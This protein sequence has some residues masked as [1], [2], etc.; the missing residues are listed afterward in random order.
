MSLQAN[1]TNN[2][3]RMNMA[4]AI[5]KYYME[6]AK[7]VI[8]DRAFPFID[9]FKPVTRFVIYDMH[10]LKAEGSTNK[11]CARI[12][13]DT[14]GRFHPHGDSSIYG[15][16]VNM[17]DVHE[18]LNAPLIKG[19][20]SF[21]KSW[22][23][24]HYVP[25]AMRYTEASLS[26][27][28]KN[29][30][31]GGL[32]EN[33]VD[34]VDNFSLEEKQPRL[35]PVSFPNILVNNTNGVAVGTS[36]YIPTYTLAGACK[37]VEALITNTEITDEELV[38]ILGAPDFCTG[39]NIHI[40]QHQMLKLVRDGY[41]KGVYLRGNYSI[42]K[43]Q[44][45]IHELPYNTT[46]ERFISEI[47]DLHV[48]GMLKGVKKIDNTSGRD[49]KTSKKK[50]NSKCKM[51][52]ELEL[53][54]GVDPEAIMKVIRQNTSFSNSIAFFTR[55]AWWNEDTQD[56]EY[57]ECG[58]RDL[59]DKYWIPWR[60]SCLRRQ[61]TFKL[62]S[63]EADYHELESW[64]ILMN[65]L[66]EYVAFARCHKKAETK[67]FLIQKLGLDEGQAN[68][69]FA[70]RLS[71]LTTDEAEKSM[72]ELKATA[73]RIAELKDIL[74]GDLRLKKMIL[75]DMRRIISKYA[76][77][78]HSNV[79]DMSMINADKE[80]KSAPEV[81]EDLPVYLAVTETGGVKRVFKE[82]NLSKLSSWADTQKVTDV[83]SCR[84]IDMLMIFTE[85]G[86]CYKIPVH[87]IDMTYGTFRDNIWRLV[88]RADDDNGRI[89]HVHATHD[90]VGGFKILY[91]N[92]TGMVVNYSAVGGK[93]QRYKSV[94]PAF[95]LGKTGIMW[96]DNKFYMVT[97]NKCGAYIDLTDL[98]TYS[99]LRGKAP[100]KLPRMKADDSL[101]GFVP[102]N[103]IEFAH[104]IKKERLSKPYCVK[105]GYDYDYILNLYHPE[106][107]NTEDSAENTEQ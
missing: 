63:A 32:N 80:E 40:T 52:I 24:E 86:Y 9:G 25:A 102:E 54:R 30:M 34:M 51:K 100:F 59:L 19:Q 33:A 87:T 14:M 8:V 103:K 35:L 64:K 27:L 44:I 84:N 31:F 15:A 6:Y 5:K 73:D 16:L 13:G 60:L 3:E 66:D 47:E 88:E 41:A 22:S 74:D 75:E 11:K 89:V 7:S 69:I 94:Y 26:D 37:A 58:V 101:L 65:H 56:Y 67:Q 105:L 107:K 2:L 39:G 46:I 36:T 28:A 17:V 71:A 21:G 61:Y 62:K 83:M 1:G 98:T 78:R 97:R 57:K 85:A 68:Y 95:E 45:I 50:S 72:N 82:E 81:V 92:G 96:N 10:L 49:T 29:E 4:D 91:L 48:K 23:S 77:E 53:T 70:K 55:F 38:E 106:E 43:N 104:C 42:N 20:G 79:F 12:V 18:T 90:Y 99:E 93:R 76:T